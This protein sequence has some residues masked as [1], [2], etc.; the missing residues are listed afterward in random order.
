MAAPEAEMLP[1]SSIFIL[2]A[3]LTYR[4]LNSGVF[5]TCKHLTAGS[6]PCKWVSAASCRCALVG[7]GSSETHSIQAADLC[8]GLA[9]VNPG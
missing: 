7:Q 5:S 1:S 2:A 3:A 4:G 8:C 6:G 9:P